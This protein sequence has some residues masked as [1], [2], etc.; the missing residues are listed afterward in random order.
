MILHFI[1]ELHCSIQQHLCILLKLLNTGKLPYSILQIMLSHSSVSQFKKADEKLSTSSAADEKTDFPYYESLLFLKP[2]I[3]HKKPLSN[4][5][6]QP[7]LNAV[8]Y[9]NAGYMFNVPTGGSAQQTSPL[10]INKPVNDYSTTLSQQYSYFNTNDT[11]PYSG[12]SLQYPTASLHSSEASQYWKTALQHTPNYVVVP[13]PHSLPCI[14]RPSSTS[15][16]LCMPVIAQPQF[17]PFLQLT[18][19]T[20]INRSNTAARK[21]PEYDNFAKKKIKLMNRDDQNLQK[22]SN[23]IVTTLDNLKKNFQSSNVEQPSSNPYSKLLT[24]AM[25]KHTPNYVVVPP[26]HS[27]PCIPRPS[28][29]STGLCMPVIAQPQFIPFPQLTPATNINRS[30]TAARKEPEYDNFAKK[31]IK[32]MNRDDQNLQK[33]SNNIVTTLDN[34]KKNCQS[35]NVEQPS[36]NPYSK[37]LTI[38]MSKHTPNYVVVPPPHSL[39][40]IPRPSSTSTGLCMPVIAQPQFIPFPQLTPATNINRSNT[41]ARKEPEYDNFAKKKI[42]LMNRDDQNLQKISNNIVTTLDNLK[43][44]CQSS[45]VEQP[46]SNP[47]SKLLTIAMSKHTPNYV[48]VPPPHSLPCIPRPSSTSTA[49]CMPVIAQPQFVPFLQLTPATNINRS[50]TAARK[51]PEYDNFAKK[52]IKLINRDDQNLQ[53]ISNNIVTTLDNLKKNFQSSNVEQPSSNPYSKLL[54]IAM[55]KVPVEQQD[56]CMEYVLEGMIEFNKRFQTS[57]HDK[58]N[59]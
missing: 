45:N 35:S 28:S 25:S 44:N 21:E 2:A 29:T 43:K 10:P 57:K 49:L 42:K 30:N 51:E 15:T 39:P 23:N 56:E 19:A 46:S 18:P 50:N 59:L 20:N 27:L 17:V 9:G 5:N 38:A 47:Y 12:A 36:S 16:A 7:T 4:L 6:V 40:C 26:P 11:A 53:K 52:K 24:I 33:I 14:P 58:N 22:I 13:P 1:L 31:K 48:V 54:T 55:S 3:K 32:L 41:A 37:L 8:H 34:L